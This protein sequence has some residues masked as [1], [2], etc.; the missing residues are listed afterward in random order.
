MLKEEDLLLGL[1]IDRIT[2][3]SNIGTAQ[4]DMY[5]SED[6]AEL[7]ADIR[8]FLSEYKD[9]NEEFRLLINRDL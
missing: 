5:I 6:F 9:K 1:E 4:L 7:Y 8:K 2:L 3:A